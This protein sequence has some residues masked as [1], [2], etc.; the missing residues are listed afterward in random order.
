MSKRYAKHISPAPQSQ[1]CYYMA[2][3]S[4]TPIFANSL[5][6]ATVTAFNRWLAEFDNVGRA[7]QNVKITEGQF[8]VDIYTG[9]VN[10]PSYDHTITHMVAYHGPADMHKP[11]FK[12]ENGDPVTQQQYAAM[13]AA[14]AAGNPAVKMNKSGFVV[15]V[16]SPEQHDLLRQSDG[17]LPSWGGG[18]L[19][20]DH[21]LAERQLAMA[22]VRCKIDFL[23][24]ATPA[25]NKNIIIRIAVS[26]LDEIDRRAAAAKLDRSEYM[27]RAALGTLQKP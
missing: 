23:H 4:P 10:A 24:D 13:V 12:I 8:L 27:R 22:G 9:S 19:S 7:A 21:A 1:P 20:T 11:A 25:K 5:Y 3:S 15:F 26:D 16:E 14:H 17:Y 2:T 18:Y 6:N